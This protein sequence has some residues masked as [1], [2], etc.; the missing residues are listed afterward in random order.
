LDDLSDE[1]LKVMGLGNRS[2]R[3][4]YFG[5][6]KHRLME[7]DDIV[8][9]LDHSDDIVL[10][11]ALPSHVI[12]SINM[13]GSSILGY[14]K[15]EIV[16]MEFKKI[17][18]SDIF[19][20]FKFPEGSRQIFR[21]VL[22][23]KNGEKIP[24]EINA[25]MVSRK[26]GKQIIIVARDLTD[27]LKIEEELRVLNSELEKRVAERTEKLQ[28]AQKQLFESEKMAAL[29]SL[30]AGVAHE[31][32]T[33]LG[34][35]FTAVTFLDMPT[36]DL[37]AVIESSPVTKEAVVSYANR[38]SEA[39]ALIRDN[40]QRAI[41]RIQQFKQIAVDQSS[42]TVRKINISK[43]LNDIADSLRPITRNHSVTIAADE[44]LSLDTDPGAIYQ[45]FSNLIVNSVIHGFKDK[46]NGQISITCINSEGIIVFDYRDNGRG[47]AEE[48]RTKIFEPFF[49]TRRN[50][51]GTGL[52]LHIVYNLVVQKLKGTI[53]YEPETDGGVRFH[54]EIPLSSSGISG[55]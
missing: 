43:Y 7:L 8:T 5:E 4:S 27:R 37:L 41:D 16:S 13:K 47:I 35:A 22:I 23:T 12:K 31:I 25:T 46:K 50:D 20:G 29:G 11:I 2:I 53:R 42:D 26:S 19:R 39:S 48:N 49:T 28:E 21:A 40:L 9:L 17:I 3:K 54:M 36:K 14:E 32:N 34:S 30:V 6:L 55:A 18:E 52:G 10:T 38:I 15:K 45:I 33:P 44:A 24:V 1:R 51:G